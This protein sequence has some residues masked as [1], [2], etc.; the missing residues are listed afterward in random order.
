VTAEEMS[1]DTVGFRLSPQQAW[2]LGAEDRHSVVQC[3]AV[4]AGPVDAARLQMALEQAAAR[5]EILRTTFPQTAGLRERS[6]LIHDVLAPGWS[7]D[8]RVLPPGDSDL[9]VRAMSAE[10]D[11]G[12][13]LEHGPLLRGLLL[14]T[15]SERPVLVLSAEAACADADSVLALL[16]ELLEQ[17]AS[18]GAGEDP[19]QYADYAEWRHA[20]IAGDDEEAAHGRELWR[21]HTAAAS[22]SG[23][24]L[25]PRGEAPGD[26]A[27]A[28]VPFTADELVRL[29]AASADAGV[30][31][32]LFLE[33]AW[34]ALTRRLSGAG[35]EQTRASW[36]SGRVQPDLEGT[37]GPY[38]QPVPV[39]T[40]VLSDTSFAEVLDQ[41]KRARAEQARWQDFASADGLA[42]VAGDPGAA[43][44]DTELGAP[45][46]GVS[47]IAALRPAPIAG[48]LLSVL[49]TGDDLRAW[50]WSAH[51]S[52]H[53]AEL[54]GRLRVLA[55]AAANDPSTP[56]AQLP[57]LQAAERE[58]LIAAGRGPDPAEGAAVP[59]HYRFEQLAAASP[60]RLAVRAAG[61]TLSYGELNAAANRLAHL[62]RDAGVRRGEAV[63]LCMARN[64]ALV[65]ALLGIVKSGGA[66]LP[67]NYEHPAAR[68]KHQLEQAG[69]RFV[70]TEA[71]L[72]DTLPVFGGEAI[73]VDRDQSRIAGFSDVDPEPVSGLEDLVYV[74]YTSGSTGVPKGVEVTHGNLANYSAELARRLAGEDPEPAG[75]RFGVVSAISTDLGNTCI[76]PPLVSGGAIQLISPGAAMDSAS[77]AGELGGERLDV[78]KITP[79]HLRALLSGEDA[80]AV[81]PRRW[82]VLG[83][84]ALSWELVDQVRGLAPECRIM[85][86]Y[87]PTE[88]TVGACAYEV[89]AV[90]SDSATVPIGHPL[91]G[92]R[93]YVL[94]RSLEP[95]PQGVAGEL[96]LGGAGVAAGYV[97]SAASD[98]A[99]TDPFVPDHLGG[100]PGRMYR[101]GDRVRRLADGALEFLGR[102]D[103]QVKIRGFRIEPGEVETVLARH[104]LVRQAAVVPETDERGE[105][106][107]V[108]YITTS[109]EPTIEE[110]Q[111]FLGES[112]PDYMVPSAFSRLDTMPFT[113]SGKVDR[114]ALAAQ[115]AGEMRRETEFVAPRDAIEEQIAGIWA[116]LLGTDQ[117]GVFDDFF[118]LGGHSLLATQAI[119]RIRREH[120]NIP[121]RALL[122]AP[123]VA[124]LADVVRSA[125]ATGG[126][127]P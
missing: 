56:V 34:D 59:F 50:V 6:Q 32:A 82:L 8:P 40:R 47:E 125:A 29:R 4:L 9:V 54:A 26:P 78:L 127:L 15:E 41:V 1:T 119:M 57:L 112:L 45:I 66:Y 106:R 87:G 36:C 21:G 37:V 91:A 39:L 23:S 35:E 5:H 107:L 17:G 14:G 20:L 58:A 92:L 3:A 76:F 25:A 48:V 19:V 83:G 28:S 55:D 108:G 11:R 95:V 60:E 30:S 89:G 99:G 101:T 75:L 46:A 100:A 12:F 117:V 111:S 85:N 98:G 94:D 42:A 38:A 84:E 80:G 63:G 96:C 13:D 121:L 103:D 105:L 52:T 114:R 79:S 10:A 18:A 86:H 69:V 33:A 102:I 73:C 31:A 123:T 113:P 126:S 51:G 118:A 7:T 93:A 104:P 64:T 16:S 81:L 97:A 74:M 77:M 68:L 43:F 90:R 124:D 61:E 72:Q 24:P 67:L 22:G 62:L 65:S 70:I 71:A 2:L 115:D 49:S 109:G 116:E 27:P 120:G 122:A 53:A 110:L 44:V 88:T